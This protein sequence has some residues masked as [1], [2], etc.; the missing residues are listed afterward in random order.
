MSKAS[1][2]LENRRQALNIYMNKLVALFDRYLPG[3]LVEFFNVEQNTFNYE[4]HQ[5]QQQDDFEN[6]EPVLNLPL[7]SIKDVDIAKLD[8]ECSDIITRGILFQLYS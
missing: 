7:I 4:Q 2:A 1:K 5:Q 6:D 8:I 3:E